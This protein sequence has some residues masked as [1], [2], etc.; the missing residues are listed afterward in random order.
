[1]ST[2]FPANHHEEC[3]VRIVLLSHTDRTG[4][5]RVGSH[6]LAREFALLGHQ[7]VH[8]SNPIS[9]ARVVLSRDEEARRRL[10]AAVPLTLHE[11]EG[12]RFA[13]PWSLLPL[14]PDPLRHPLTLGSTTLLRRRLA[15]VGMTDVDLMLVDQPLLDYLVNP[16]GTTRLVLRPTDINTDPLAQRAEQRLLGRADAVV[17]TSSAVAANLVQGS[18]TV[19]PMAVVE[20]GVD[21]DH[22]QASATPWDQRRGAVYVGALDQRFD[23]SALAEMAAANPRERLDVFGPA[24]ADPE[25]MPSNVTLRG[26]VPYEAMPG[27]LAGYRVGLLPLNDDPTNRGRSPMKLYEYL[28]TG[29]TVVTRAT[30][31]TTARGLSDVRGYDAPTEAG[32]ALRSALEASPS[33]DG[34]LAAAEMGWSARARL[35]LA[36]AG[37]ARF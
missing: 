5:F 6:H 37:S 4:V 25:T 10:R 35:V 29:L 28:A 2:H 20:N 31:T 32:D 23:W 34:L 15:R 8:I 27:L 11:I 13:I 14:T 30:P 7:V 24:P 26:A 33:G 19:P 12:A 17:A 21:L 1:L 16:I 18:I 36:A 3:G 9:V 22:F